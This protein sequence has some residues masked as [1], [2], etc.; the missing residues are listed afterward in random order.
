MRTIDEFKTSQIEALTNMLRS[1][2][3]P[4][5][6]YIHSAMVRSKTRFI[7]LSKEGESIKEHCNFMLYEEMNCYC[8]GYQKASKSKLI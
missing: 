3:I 5:K 1:S 2:G 4:E 6:Y 8:F 7:I